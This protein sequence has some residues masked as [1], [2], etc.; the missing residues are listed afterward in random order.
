MLKYNISANLLP[1]ERT[2]N[3]FDNTNEILDFIITL[4]K[5]NYYHVVT[6]DYGIPYISDHYPIIINLAEYWDND[7]FDYG[8]NV[9]NKQKDYEET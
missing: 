8:H 1:K 6:E 9:S 3:H 2:F 7:E 5:I 4:N